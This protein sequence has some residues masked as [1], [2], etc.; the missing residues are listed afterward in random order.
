MDLIK[1][2]GNIFKFFLNMFSFV[3]L[4]GLITKLQCFF[5]F[6]HRHNMATGVFTNVS[7]RLFCR[8]IP[9]DEI[10]SLPRFRNNKT[11]VKTQ[12]PAA[13]QQSATPKELRGWVGA[14]WWWWVRG[15]GGVHRTHNDSTTAQSWHRRKTFTNTRA[16]VRTHTH[17]VY[18]H[19]SQQHTQ[20]T[21]SQHNHNH[22]TQ[23]TTS[24]RTHTSLHHRL[25]S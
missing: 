13:H 22:M 6:V 1:K 11:T 5:V 20:Q 21:Q 12:Q 2:K 14:G 19:T 16:H 9:P 25:C 4:L 15:G 7:Q 3:L 17:T 23:R 10:R 18:K 8:R 24:P